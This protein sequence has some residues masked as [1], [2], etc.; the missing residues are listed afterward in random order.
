MS[1]F[2]EAAAAVGVLIIGGFL[3]L[4]MAPHLGA[5][6]AMNPTFWGVIYILA[7]ILGG[8]III[9]GVVGALFSR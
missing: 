3:F 4:K 2:G 6:G 8:V 7:G 1:D 5:N 9:G